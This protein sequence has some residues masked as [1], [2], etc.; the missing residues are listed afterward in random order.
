MR[1][2]KQKP[3]IHIEPPTSGYMKESLI[4][5]IERISK[6]F[7]IKSLVTLGVTG[8]FIWVASR[9]N[10]PQEVMTIYSVIIGFY[11]GTQATKE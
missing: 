2:S 6:L 4:G 11:F 5:L 3:S 9:G 1:R 10:I 7:S 8:L